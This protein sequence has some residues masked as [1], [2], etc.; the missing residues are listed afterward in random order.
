MRMSGRIRGMKRLSRF[1]KR[2]PMLTQAVLILAGLACVIVIEGDL[3]TFGA[4]VYPGLWLI[5]PDP[6]NPQA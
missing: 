5:A 4:A 6:S 2:Y 1:A 3:Q